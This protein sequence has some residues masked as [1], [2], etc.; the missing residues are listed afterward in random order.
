M[1]P[2]APSIQELQ[3]T[4]GRKEPLS[5]TTESGVIEQSSEEPEQANEEID[6]ETIYMAIAT[7]DSTVVYYRLSRGIKKPADIP[8][9]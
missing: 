7:T 8:D 2:L 9:E 5:P 4:L 3:A 1:D 6:P